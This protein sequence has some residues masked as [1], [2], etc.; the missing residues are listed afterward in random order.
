KQ[1]TPEYSVFITGN[2]HLNPVSSLAGRTIL[3]SSDSYLYYHGF[4]TTKRRAEV[5]AFYENPGDNLALLSQ[6]GVSY[7]YVSDYERS[8]SWFTLNEAALEALFPVAYE[9]ESGRLRI[10]E[11]PQGLQP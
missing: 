11:V 4:D 2:Q 5:A 3:C 9:S 6:Y 1:N 7:L 10:F 8:S